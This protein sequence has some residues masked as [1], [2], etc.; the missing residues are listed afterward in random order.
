MNE[1]QASP[2]SGA[3]ALSKVMAACSMILGILPPALT[4]FGFHFASLYNPPIYEHQEWFL[5]IPGITAIIASWFVL[6]NR[7][8]SMPVIAGV[9]LV[10]AVIVFV[11]YNTLPA[12]CTIGPINIHVINWILSYCVVAL[13]IA[14]LFGFF[15]TLRG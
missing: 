14:L 8:T 2:G 3:D 11:V 12:N 7:Q 10:L 5:T 15:L 13:A 1:T 6:T 4:G 9:S